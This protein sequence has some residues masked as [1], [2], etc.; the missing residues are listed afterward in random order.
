MHI[1]TSVKFAIVEWLNCFKKFK[2]SFS[3]DV[4][5]QVAVG[6]HARLRSS[7]NLGRSQTVKFDD[8]ITNIG[9]N[10]DPTLGHFTAPYHRLYSFSATCLA[11]GDFR[12]RLVMFHNSNVVSRGRASNAGYA[13]GAMNADVWLERNDIV[14]IRSNIFTNDRIYGPW[15]YFTGHLL[16]RNV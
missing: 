15:S 1:N 3:S 4:N 14:Y 9:D 8:V 13:Q 2:M 10:Y 11:V 12:L 7:I 6:F 16:S 5:G